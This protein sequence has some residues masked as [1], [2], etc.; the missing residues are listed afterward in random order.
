MLL[1]CAL[2]SEVT[3]T[4]HPFFKLRWLAVTAKWDRDAKEEIV[5]KLLIRNAKTFVST[6]K[7]CQSPSQS[8][9]STSSEDDDYFSFNKRNQSATAAAAAARERSSTES[10]VEMQIVLYL[11][12]K[13]HTL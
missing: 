3:A 13:K 1:L 5:K 11:N 4:T 9:F 12:S 2:V 6:N 10:S 7:T 8:C